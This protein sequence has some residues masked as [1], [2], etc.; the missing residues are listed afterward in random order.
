[1]AASPVFFK[2]LTSAIGSGS[3]GSDSDSEDSCDAKDFYEITTNEA[4]SLSTYGEE[5]TERLELVLE[6]AYNCSPSL[7]SKS[8][9]L[10]LAERLKEILYLDKD[11][12]G[13]IEDVVFEKSGLA[14]RTPLC[15]NS[16]QISKISL[17]MKVRARVCV[18]II[19]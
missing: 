4:K 14:E 3:D 11:F 6:T 12:K 17:T 13:F 16:T 19:I 9:T 15:Q 1:M 2:E 8:G 5:D 18:F 10:D 7:F